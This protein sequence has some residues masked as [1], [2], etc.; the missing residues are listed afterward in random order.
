MPGLAHHGETAAHAEGSWR[1]SWLAREHPHSAGVARTASR[2]DPAFMS[3][4]SPRVPLGA[5]ARRTAG[6]QRRRQHHH[7]SPDHRQPDDDGRPERRLTTSGGTTEAPTPTTG[8]LTTQGSMGGT[9]TSTTGEPTSTS[10]TMATETGVTANHQRRRQHD[11]V[12]TIGETSTTT[13]NESSR[14]KVCVCDPASPTAARWATSDLHGRL[15]GLRAGAVSAGSELLR[16]RAS[17]LCEPNESCATAS[18]RPRSVT[19]RGRLRAA[20]RVRV[21]QE[22][23]VGAC[24]E[25]CELVKSNPSSVVVCSAATRC[26]TSRRSRAR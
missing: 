4:L 14:G 22:C 1:S 6:L 17:Q 25:L 9:T 11:G 24:T 7:V 26:K 5:P 13:G 23:S 15:R 10:T 3:K 16:T 19:R 20:G 8:D 12:V 21:T 18:V 2:R